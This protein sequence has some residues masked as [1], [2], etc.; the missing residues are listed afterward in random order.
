MRNFYL[1]LGVLFLFSASAF[2][3]TEKPSG[4]VLDS[5]TSGGVRIVEY[6]PKG[7]CA[8]RIHIEVN[9]EGVLENVVFTRS[10]DGNSRGIGVLLKGMKVQDAIDKLKGITCGKRKTSCPDQLAQAL[11]NMQEKKSNIF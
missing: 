3:Q 2:A 1:L 5:L 9:K 11:L 6:I 4:I 10:C 8:N 7:V